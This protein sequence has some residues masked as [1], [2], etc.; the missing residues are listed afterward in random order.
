MLR[1]ALEACGHFEFDSRGNMADYEPS[2]T[3]RGAGTAGREVRTGHRPSMAEAEL[4]VWLAS[5]AYDA[6]TV[7]APASVG[8]PARRLPASSL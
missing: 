6:Q 7:D 2:P 4:P 5:P 1:N 8:S 3:G